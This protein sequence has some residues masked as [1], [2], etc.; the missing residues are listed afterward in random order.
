MEQCRTTT[1][2]AA[3]GQTIALLLL[4]L[5]GV[6]CAERGDPDPVLADLPMLYA[7]QADDSAP[8]VVV[9][10]TIDSQEYRFVIDTCCSSTTF[11]RSLRSVLGATVGTT[12]S[13]RNLRDVTVEVERCEV[14]KDFHM[15]RI[16]L[17]GA[18]ECLDLAA[19]EGRKTP[20]PH[21]GIIGMDVL[22]GKVLD[23]DL[24]NRRVRLLRP[25][26]TGESPYGERSDPIPLTRDRHRFAVVKIQLADSVEESF[27]LDTGMLGANWL[28]AELFEQIKDRPDVRFAQGQ[29]VEMIVV[30]EMR[31][32]DIVLS[33]MTFVRGTQSILG[34]AFLARVRILTLNLRNNRLY[35]EPREES[36]TESVRAVHRFTAVG[37]V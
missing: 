3:G 30:D 17:T 9:P 19:V 10:L 34:T 20:Y 32:G 8:W 1:S 5:T 12:L 33:N 16:E 23:L 21:N 24:I 28:R 15:G 22:D 29:N 27:L 11:D 7:D 26:S 25:E 35:L 36:T 2:L 18:V 6:G 4:I 13:D 31:I 37:R 14:P